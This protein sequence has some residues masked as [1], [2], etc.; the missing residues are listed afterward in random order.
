MNETAIITFDINTTDSDAKLGVEIWLDHDC[1]YKNN[2]ITA[3]H[4]FSHSMIDDDAEHELRIV[5]LGKT[6]ENTKVDEQGNIVRDAFLIISNPSID[7]ID[8][9]QLFNEKTVYTH[10]FN[11]TQSQSPHKFYGNLGCNGTVSLQFSTPIYLWM[12]ENM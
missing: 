7:G 9:A 3:L 6:F 11:G 10:D 5:M 4:N 1:V 2:H 8:V 12:L